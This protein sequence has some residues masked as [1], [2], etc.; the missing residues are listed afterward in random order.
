MSSGKADPAAVV[1]DAVSTLKRQAEAMKKSQPGNKAVAQAADNAVADL[2]RKAESLKKA[3]AAGKADPAHAIDDTLASV[4]AAAASLDH[5]SKASQAEQ[6][7]KGITGEREAGL[8][9]GRRLPAAAA[10]AWWLWCVFVCC[11][12]SN[13]S[14]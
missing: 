1:D 12:S 14:S 7:V 9:Q 3:M 2:S 11:V 8:G 5:T 13:A 10:P 4:S 6:A